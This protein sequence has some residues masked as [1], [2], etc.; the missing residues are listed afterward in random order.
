MSLP[1]IH[2]GDWGTVRHFGRLYMAYVVRVHRTRVE[3]SYIT[4]RGLKLWVKTRGVAWAAEDLHRGGTP[5]FLPGFVERPSP[6]WV[7]SYAIEI[8]GEILR[9]RKAR[10]EKLTA[11]DETWLRGEFARGGR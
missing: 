6:P 4:Q 7:R 3:V 8:K 1:G 11:A 9:A 2:R 5:L 10:G